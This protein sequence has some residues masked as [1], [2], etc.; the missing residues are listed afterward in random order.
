MLVAYC[1]RLTIHFRRIRSPA[2]EAGL[3]RG[4]RCPVR[5]LPGSRRKSLSYRYLSSLAVPILPAQAVSPGS[6][7]GVNYA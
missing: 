2:P 5:V 6:L 4:G 7:P 1:G 3:R